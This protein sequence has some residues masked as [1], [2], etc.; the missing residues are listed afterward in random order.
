MLNN[1]DTAPSTSVNR[2]IVSILTFHFK[3]Q[4]VPGKIH[5]PDGLSCRPPQ[6]GDLDNNEDPDAFND[7]V[8]H[9]YGFLHLLNPTTPAPQT[10]DLLYRFTTEQS[11]IPESDPD[12]NNAQDTTYAGP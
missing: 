7:W 4:H 12:P 3:L 2:W 8:N 1:P 9:L 6:P 11:L 5:R 10:N